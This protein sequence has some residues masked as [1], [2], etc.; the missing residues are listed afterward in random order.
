MFASNKWLDLKLETIWICFADHIL[1]LWLN[2]D[3][4]EFDIFMMMRISKSQTI[5]KYSFIFIYAQIDLHLVDSF[6]LVDV[7]DDF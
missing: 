5:K 6:L 1:W 4:I 7:Y 3:Q 2:L